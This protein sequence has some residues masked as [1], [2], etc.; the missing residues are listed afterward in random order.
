MIKYPNIDSNNPIYTNE[1]PN[2]VSALPCNDLPFLIE[3]NNWQSVDNFVDADVIPIYLKNRNEHI[4]QIDYLKRIGIKEHQVLLAMLLYD[5]TETYDFTSLFNDFKSALREHSNYRVILVHNNKSLFK[6]CINPCENIYYDHMWNRTKAYYTDY[7]NVRPDG[8]I[9]TYSATKKSWQLNPIH[10]KEN[11]KV[12]LTPNRIFPF[13]SPRLAYRKLLKHYLKDKNGY[14]SD[15]TNGVI[16][17][18]EENDLLVSWNDRNH[19]G[20][21]HWWPLANKY[22]ETSFVSI[23]VETITTSNTNNYYIQ[24]HWTAISEKCY[25]PLIKGHFLLPFGYKGIIKDLRDMGFIFPTFINYEYDNVLEDNFR[26]A[27]FIEE[28]NRL[29][30]IS[31]SDWDNY[32]AQHKEMLEH[33]RNVFFTRPYSPFY[34]ELRKIL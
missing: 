18:T 2:Y 6:H 8:K 16:L 27:D 29:T 23:L 22:Y 15:P 5:D 4:P 33:N 30:S 3:K 13:I 17:E 1:L 31:V 9:Y 26:F 28:V 7:D 34:G 32:F 20:G 11:C 21:G 19:Y 10:K 24:N 25:D 14:M 12:F